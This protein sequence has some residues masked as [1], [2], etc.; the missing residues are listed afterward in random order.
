VCVLIFYYTI[1]FYIN[2]QNVQLTPLEK[3][4]KSNMKEAVLV[5]YLTL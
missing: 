3:D 4:E 2:Y 1:M 5:I